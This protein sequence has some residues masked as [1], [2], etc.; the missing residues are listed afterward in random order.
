MKK[1]KIL[2]FD[3]CNENE[4][5]ILKNIFS[6]YN[7]GKQ[8]I[9]FSINPEIIVNKN[10]DNEYIQLLNNEKYQIPDGIGIVY[11]SKLN[12]GKIK[13]RI[14]GI[15]MME[16]LCKES[17]NYKSKIFLYGAKAGVAEDAKIQLEKKY[18]GINIVQTCNGYIEE[19]I[20]LDNIIKVKPDI[21]FVGLGSP[22]QEEFILNN[23]EKLKNI[24]IL[25]PVGGSFDVISQNLSRAPNWVIKMN[26]EW[27]HRLVKQP[28]RIFRQ[29][30]LLKFIFYVITNKIRKK[31]KKNVKN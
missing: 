5:K 30:K 24:R 3:V 18:S 23:K 19:S 20:A 26:L 27:L 6:D 12:K 15:D 9:I 7:E 25:M 21:L 28:I 10:K 13:E 14:T 17:V 4:E 31:E 29:I 2:G 22:K 8:S 1:E 11:A 16:K